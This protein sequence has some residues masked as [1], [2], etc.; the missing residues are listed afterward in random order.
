[1]PQLSNG[2]E[3]AT[4]EEA[5]IFALDRLGYE[6]LKEEKE[7]VLKTFIGG[8]DVFAALPTGYGK[9]LGFALLPHVFDHLKQQSRSIVICISPL[10]SL[11]IDQ[12]EKFHEPDWRLSLLGKHCMIHM[13]LVEGKVQLLCIS[14]E[15]LLISSEW[16]EMLQS[17]IYCENL[18][19]C[20]VDE[21]HCVKQW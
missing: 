12:K 15:S 20:V 16:G 13:L 18:V 11:M 10:T 2:P 4:M 9:S 21:A 3:K 5:F 19:A 8:R 14:P 7:K 1:M 17:D 6:K